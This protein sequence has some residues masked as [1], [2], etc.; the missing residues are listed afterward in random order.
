M[1]PFEPERIVNPIQKN[2]NLGY[3]S[4]I[5]YRVDIIRHRMHNTTKG[6]LKSMY[7]KFQDFWPPP[8]F[9][10]NWLLI[11]TMKFTHL[12]LINAPFHS[13]LPP[14]ILTYFIDAPPPKHFHFRPRWL[15]CNNFFYRSGIIVAWGSIQLKKNCI[16]NYIQNGIPMPFWKG[17]LYELASEARF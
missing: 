8:P 13:L 6:H 10:R 9:C 1:I 12:P 11:F 5:K 3:S 16:Q 4:S 7:P 15:Q 14:L 2:L 17:H